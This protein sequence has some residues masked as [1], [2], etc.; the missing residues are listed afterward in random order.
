MLLL[1]LSLYVQFVAQGVGD[2]LI[3]LVNARALVDGRRLYWR[4]VYPCSRR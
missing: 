3:L 1:C 2:T 4:C